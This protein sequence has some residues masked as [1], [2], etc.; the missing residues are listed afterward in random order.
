MNWVCFFL[1]FYVCC[2][3]E[4]RIICTWDPRSP[5][6]IRNGFS[7]FIFFFCDVFPATVTIITRYIRVWRLFTLA[8]LHATG[9][10][11]TLFCCHFRYV[12]FRLVI[13]V[14]H[15]TKASHGNTEGIVTSCIAT[16]RVYLRRLTRLLCGRTACHL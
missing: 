15:E 11:H 16:Y 14:L 12:K 5:Q 2:F 7:Y 3:H 8:M 9:A 4:R 10:S 6:L 1:L 13:E